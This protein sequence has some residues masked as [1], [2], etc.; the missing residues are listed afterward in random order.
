MRIR[1]ISS[2][3]KVINMQYNKENK[4]A[5]GENDQDIFLFRKQ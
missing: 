5:Y 4:Y 2:R 3:N 1:I